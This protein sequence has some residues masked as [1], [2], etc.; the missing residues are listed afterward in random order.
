M[1]ERNFEGPLVLVKVGNRA[2]PLADWPW[3]DED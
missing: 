3:L 1:G 2:E